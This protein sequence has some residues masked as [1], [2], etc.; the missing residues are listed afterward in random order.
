VLL[1]EFQRAAVT[2]SE[3]IVF[4]EAAAVPHRPNRVDHVGGLEPITP[5][6]LGIA[7]L[8]AVERTT[9]GDEIG[10]CGTV[11][12]PIDAAAAEQRRIRGVDDGV[13]AQ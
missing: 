6:D 7:G 8:A 3:Q 11:N 5:G 9:F 10:A 12:G 2:G 4:A 13:N 1:A